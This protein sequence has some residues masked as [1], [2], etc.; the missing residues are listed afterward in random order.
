MSEICAVCGLPLAV[1]EFGCIATVRPHGRLSG[2]VIDDTIIGGFVQENFGTEPET[3]Y[4][5]KDMARRAKELGLMPFVRNA[6][7]NDRHVPVW[8]TTDPYTM[9]AAEALVARMK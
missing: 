5:K 8:S 9:A 4:S 1:G 3:F 2:T 7:P 6:G